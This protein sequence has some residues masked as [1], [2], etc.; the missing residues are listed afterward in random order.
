M[1][2]VEEQ[3]Q[4]EGV[5][6]NRFSDFYG[7]NWGVEEQDDDVGSDGDWS[8]LFSGMAELFE[9]FGEPEVCGVLCAEGA[10]GVGAEASSINGVG[11]D[12]SINGAVVL[13][14]QKGENR[15]SGDIKGELA[16]SVP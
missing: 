7:E 12:Y 6:E 15:I 1:L 16:E 4:D 8:P 14:E 2:E 13:P 5:G 11:A 10:G 9:L 3:E